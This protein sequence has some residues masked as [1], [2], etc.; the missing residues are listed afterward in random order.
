MSGSHL[1]TGLTILLVFSLGLPSCGS[2]KKSEKAPAPK[3]SSAPEPAPEPEPEGPHPAKAALDG[4]VALPEGASAATKMKALSAAYR[5]HL[6]GKILAERTK[7]VALGGASGEKELARLIRERLREQA[8]KGQKGP[9]EIFVSD[10]MKKKENK[11][12]EERAKA[13]FGKSCEELKDLEDDTAIAAWFKSGW[14]SVRPEVGS[15]FLAD[16]RDF[17]DRVYLLFDGGKGKRVTVTMVADEG[18]FRY[19][20][21]PEDRDAYLKGPERAMLYDLKTRKQKNEAADLL[22]SQLQSGLLDFKR[23]M[24]RWPTKIEGLEGLLL[25]VGGPEGQKWLGPY[26][27]YVHD[28]WGNRYRLAIPGI[29]NTS[30]YDVWSPGP[31]GKDG[32]TDDIKNW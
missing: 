3:P 13:V 21:T 19:A 27:K 6:Q 17:V 22:L 25:P 7:L 28:P 4:L 2:K 24:E 14:K 5:E 26:A 20:G 23:N 1:S 12:A 32:T 11:E 10:A 18:A 15:L 16:L 8:K 31:D 9:I 30:F 29:H